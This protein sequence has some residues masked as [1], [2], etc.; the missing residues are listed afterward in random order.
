MNHNLAI[1]DSFIVKPQLYLDDACKGE[2]LKQ[3]VVGC[4]KTATLRDTLS[5]KQ[6]KISSYVYF[7]QSFQVFDAYLRNVAI[8]SGQSQQLGNALQLNEAWYSY[9]Q[10]KLIKS[11]C[12]GS[13]LGDVDS[14]LHFPMECELYSS[15][16]Q[17]ENPRFIPFHNDEHT[18][19]RQIAAQK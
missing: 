2:W 13:F 8:R 15:K 7:A 11:R 14:R 6:L 4:A 12:C 3:S 18:P 1:C 10:R 19:S 16:L 9:T 5:L 17:P